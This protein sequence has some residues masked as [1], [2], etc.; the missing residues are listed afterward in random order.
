MHEGKTETIIIH[1]YKNGFKTV[2]ADYE[3]N[4][5]TLLVH[6]YMFPI[7]FSM[8]RGPVAMLLLKLSSF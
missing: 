6:Y 2:N 4:N 5:I 7:N 3:L 8:I 1:L